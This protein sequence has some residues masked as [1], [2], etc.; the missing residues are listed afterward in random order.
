[1]DINEVQLGKYRHFKGNL[2]ELIEVAHHSESQEPVAVYRALYG[3][4][5]LWVRPLEMFLETIERDGAE[6]QRFQYIKA[7]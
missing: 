5:G 3:D 6:I 4:H 1:M 7:E 2:Y